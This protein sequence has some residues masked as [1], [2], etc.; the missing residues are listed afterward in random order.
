MSETTNNP[1]TENKFAWAK[2][3]DEIAGKQRR[4]FSNFLRRV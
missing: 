2:E 3:A 1:E 4:R